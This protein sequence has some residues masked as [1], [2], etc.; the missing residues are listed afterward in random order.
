MWT[1]ASSPA[2]CQLQCLH[3][4]CGNWWWMSQ[5][6]LLLLRRI[7]SL[8]AGVPRGLHKASRPI[9][10][11]WLLCSHPTSTQLCSSAPVL[12]IFSSLSVALTGISRWWSYAVISSVC[13]GNSERQKWSKYF[14]ASGSSQSDTPGKEKDILIRIIIIVFSFVLSTEIPG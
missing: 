14:Q 3:L 11:W 10:F 12:F 1:G 8:P 5:N 4:P 6:V 2:F 9:A 13:L 7:P